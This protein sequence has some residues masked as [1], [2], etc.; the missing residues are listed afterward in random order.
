VA[1]AT[2]GDGYR[3][4]RG[5]SL[6]EAVFAT[7]LVA[8][9]L[10]GVA[11][12]FVVAI[13][14]NHSSGT[15]T[16]ATAL[17]SQKMEELRG[18]A[19]HTDEAGAAV[20]DSASDLSVTPAAPIGGRGLRPSPL[21]TLS[22][23]TPGYVDYLG[24]AGQWVGTGADTPR[25]A[26]FVRRWSVTPLPAHPDDALILQ[27]YVVKASAASPGVSRQPGAAA[28]VSLRARKSR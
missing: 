14:V 18:L 27:V 26:V 6:L 7:L 25:D 4:Q 15:T 20:T 13:A 21:E 12:L 23:N 2:D 1:G 17:A 10:A 28:L 19:F 24:V 11:Q 8:A 9:G 3:G 22:T 5:F 16:T